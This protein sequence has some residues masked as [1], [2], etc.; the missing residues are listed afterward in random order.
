MLAEYH[1]GLNSE[2]LSQ[3]K[4]KKNKQQHKQTMKPQTSN[5]PS[6][7][8]QNQHI[9]VVPHF[10]IGWGDRLAFQLYP[11]TD[12]TRIQLGTWTRDTGMSFTGEVSDRAWSADVYQS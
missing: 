3:A 5:Q 8:K 1:P 4:Q 6:K 7:L 2:A 9:G 12:V 10:V 11:V